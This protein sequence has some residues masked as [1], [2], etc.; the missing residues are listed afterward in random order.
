MKPFKFNVGQKVRVMYDDENYG[1]VSRVTH[2][3]HH[4]SGHNIYRLRI[5]GDGVSYCE[6]FLARVSDEVP[7]GWEP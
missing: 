5:S 6:L 7:R 4:S 2:R 1:K 3:S